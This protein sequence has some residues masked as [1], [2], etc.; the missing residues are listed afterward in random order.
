VD[1]HLVC[2]YCH[3]LLEGDL[4]EVV[5]P[6]TT[7]CGECNRAQLCE[8]EIFERDAADGELDGEFE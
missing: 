2:D 1:A 6:S 7:I 8:D 3:M 5:T 4:D